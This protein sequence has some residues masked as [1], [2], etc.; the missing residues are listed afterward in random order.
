MASS[1]GHNGHHQAISQKL[2]KA[3]T[4]HIVQNRPFIWDHIYIY[5]NIYI[6]TAL[7]LLAALKCA[8]YGMM[9]RSSVMDAV[10]TFKIV[11]SINS[12]K[13]CYLQYYVPQFCYGW[14][15]YI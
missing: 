8:I 3:G 5:I 9:C 4:V 10:S 1:F 13:M 6:L 15:E 11:T 7:K 2:K 12:L 14:C